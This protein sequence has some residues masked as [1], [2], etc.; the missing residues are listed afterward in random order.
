MA[1]GHRGSGFSRWLG[2]ALHLQ[3]DGSTQ[4]EITL[5]PEQEGPPG[6]SHGGV[7]VA[8]IDEAMGMAVWA[9]GFRVLAVNLNVN[10]RRP[11]PLGVPVIVRGRLLRVE[12]RKAFTSGEIILPDGMVAAE[13]SGI[14]V[15]APAD[16]AARSHYLDP[17]RKKE[18]G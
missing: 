9:T 18:D 8:M 3:Q 7:I 10:F 5:G 4:A 11:L 1:S 15:Q 16:I 12:G 17:N 2:L 6:H 14:F 13:G